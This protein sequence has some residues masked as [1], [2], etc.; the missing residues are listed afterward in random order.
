MAKLFVFRHGQ[1]A[2]NRNRIFTGWH[3]SELTEDGIRECE[4]V[5]RQL[6][7]EKPTKAYTSDLK[8]AQHTLYIILG[9]EKDRVP[10]IIDPRIKERN[11]GE[12]NGR[13]KAET[14]R[15][16]PKEYPLWH[17]SYDVPPPGGESIKDVEKR[18]VSFLDEM[19][20]KLK[21]DDVVF[22]SVH[23]NSLRP[24]RRYFEGISVE[25]MCS[26]EHVPGRVYRYDV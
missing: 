2:Y 19:I 20:P 1:T 4:D 6:R 9:T 24:I 22:I 26:F 14:E 23:G 18:V 5:A 3:D 8:R 15:K 25:E 12:L 21:K 13:S 7:G 17:R 11:Y 16:Y 10:V